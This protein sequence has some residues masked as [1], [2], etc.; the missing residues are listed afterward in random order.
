MYVLEKNLFITYLV[1]K[2]DKIN[3]ENLKHC[4]VKKLLCINKNSILLLE[5]MSITMLTI[6]VHYQSNLLIDF[7]VSKIANYFLIF[8][9]LYIYVCSILFWVTMSEGNDLNS[10]A[11]F[12]LNKSVLSFF[13]SF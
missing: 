10:V 5:Q 12:F 8:L 9:M 4:F 1:K 7:R 2:R 3:F 13:L 11:S 6:N